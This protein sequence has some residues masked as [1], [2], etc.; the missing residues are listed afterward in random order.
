VATEWRG[1]ARSIAS[2]VP[3]MRT[4]SFIFNALIV[5]GAVAVAALAAA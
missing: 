5:I 2:V 1:N 4:A 3:R